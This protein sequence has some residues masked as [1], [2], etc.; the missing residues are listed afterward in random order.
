MPFAEDDDVI[1]ALAAWAPTT[2]SPIEFAL[3]A[4]I[5]VGTL[6]MPIAASRAAKLRPRPDR[7]HGLGTSVADHKPWPR[8]SAAT[9]RRRPG[10]KS[11]GSGGALGDRD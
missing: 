11:L 2:R 8:S 3:G 1:E 5:G 10:G 9:S 7:D 6:L 4:R